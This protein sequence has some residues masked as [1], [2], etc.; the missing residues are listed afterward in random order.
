MA[1]EFCKEEELIKPIHGHIENTPI[2]Y[3]Y[4]KCIPNRTAFYLL[5]HGHLGKHY[6][7]YFS[8]YFILK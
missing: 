6:I 2:A 7:I 4:F 3:D 1:N 8:N 5:S